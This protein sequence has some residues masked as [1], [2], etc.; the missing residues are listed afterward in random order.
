MSDIEKAKELFSAGEYTCVLVKDGKVFTSCLGGIAP[1]V[2]F[3]KDG[4]DLNGFSA[5]DR[6]VGKAAALLFVLAGV[7]EVF[8]S[9]LSSAAE[10]VF[11][12]HAVQYSFETA[13]DVIINRAGTG[14][15]PMEN[16]VNGIDDPR[17]AYDAI[18]RTLEILRNEKRRIE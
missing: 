14:P 5:S 4:A 11:A 16:A 12:Q 9:V 2:G 1:M 17:E 15:C 18:N 3:I 10:E 8:A 7:K 6:I 13:T